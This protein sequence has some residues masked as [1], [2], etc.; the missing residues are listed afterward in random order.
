LSL[1]PLSFY[2]SGMHDDFNSTSLLY[3]AVKR[4]QN[5]SIQRLPSTAF[6]KHHQIIKP[7]HHESSPNAKS[8]Y[9]NVIPL[10]AL[11]GHWE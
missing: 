3:I 8:C 10:L 2:A 11:L 6:G 9:I 1:L 5:K 7:V 4:N